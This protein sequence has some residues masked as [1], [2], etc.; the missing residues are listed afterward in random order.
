MRVVIAPDKFKGS[1][2][3]PEAAEAM[4]RGVIAAR[5]DAAIDRVPMADGGEGTVAALV[6]ATGGTIHQSVVTGPLGEPVVAAFG[7]LGDGRT[8]VIEMA[9]ASGLALVP[10]AGRNPSRTTT[11]GTGELIL[12]AERAGARRIILGIGGSA[13]NDGGAGMA[14][15]LGYRLLDSPGNE[16]GPGGGALE[17]L[18]RIER[19]GESD[20][21]RAQIEIACD[22]DNPLC[23]PRGASAIYGPQ[24]GATPEMVARLDANLRHL[25]AI[26]ERDL[27]IAVAERPGAGAAGGLGAGLVAFAAGTLRPGVEL[28]IEAVGLRG[29]LA[30]ADLCLTGE[31]AIDTQTAHGKTPVGVARLARSLEVPTLALA[32]TLGEG[33]DAVLGEGIDAYFSICPGPIPL[34]RALADAGLLLSRATE[35]AVRAFLAGRPA[36]TTP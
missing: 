12:A 25:A 3:A 33:A 16:L 14:Q 20:E 4:A 24:K 22:V 23:G 18:D 10:A 7:M 9:A 17:G 27:G 35:Q 30:G 8:A 34:E 31:G 32:G 11:R 36:E 5:P 21:R 6:S 28:V 15:A 19:T 29:R 26:I 13:T 1:L 2:T